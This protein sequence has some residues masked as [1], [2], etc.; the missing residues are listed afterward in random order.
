MQLIP[1][2]KILGAKV[3]HAD[4]SAPLSLQDRQQI[5]N[6]LGEYSV[7]AFEQ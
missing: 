1:E 5:I 7:L 3:I 2:N 4:L 6:W